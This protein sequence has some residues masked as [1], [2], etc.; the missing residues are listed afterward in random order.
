MIVPFLDVGFTY[1]D[2]KVDIDA[3]IQ[4]VLDSG[5]Y[6]QG[7][8]V[9]AFEAQYA[10]WCG[11]RHCVGTGNGLDALVLALEAV[12]VGPGDEVIVPEHTFIATWLAVSRIGAT[13]V[14]VQPDPHTYQISVQHCAA[15]ITSRTRAIIPVHIYGHPCDMP[16]IMQ[17]AERYSLKVVTDAAQAH[18]ATI[19]G[20]NIGA[21]G[22]VVAWSFY[23]GKNLGAFGDGGAITTDNEVLAERIRQLGNY[24]S[25]EK[26]VHEIAGVNS[27][28]D[29]MQAAAMRVKLSAIDRW[30]QRRRDIAALYQDR[31][32]NC[33][34]TLPG[35]ADWANPSWHLYVVQV[36][37]RDAF[38]RKLADNGVPTAI[39]YPLA[40][41]HQGAYAE[42]F[43][44][45]S[46]PIA[47]SIAKH[48]VSLPIGPHISL[49]Q[50]DKI[51][52]TICDAARK[53]AN[54]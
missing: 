53:L 52:D 22:D 19:N 47:E 26:Y 32:Q 10:E 42:A 31:L 16:A 40:C 48:C 49:E 24:G 34:L 25:R 12:G 36:P 11:A 18:G 27:R 20:E 2:L 6:I 38:I 41:H 4:R 37:D 3:A 9:A 43:E 54:I 33:G 35:V 21:M 51:C 15:A 29:P 39:H 8:E 17:L 28:L 30:T 7:E 23:P 45:R 13:P 1:R 5:W 46:F 14:P 50:A 44:G